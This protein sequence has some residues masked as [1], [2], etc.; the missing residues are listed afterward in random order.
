[1]KVFGYEFSY[2]RITDTFTDSLIKLA[3]E[4][5]TSPACI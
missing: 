1:M 5:Q 4:E 3:G 2:F